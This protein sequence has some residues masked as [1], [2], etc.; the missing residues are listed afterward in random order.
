MRDV[1]DVAVREYCGKGKPFRSLVILF[2]EFGRYTELATVRSHIAGSGALQDC[3]RLFSH[4][5]ARLHSL[6]LSNLS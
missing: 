5:K 2:D 1:L 6:D 3:S 4:T